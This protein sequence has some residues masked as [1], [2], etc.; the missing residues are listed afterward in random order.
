MT[1]TEKDYD[2]IIAPM[3]AVAGAPTHGPKLAKL[4]PPASSIIDWSIPCPSIFLTRE[5]ARKQSCKRPLAPATMRRIAAGLVK[6]VLTAAKPFIVRIGQT[7]WGDAGKVSD[8][9]QP[10][11]TV[12]SKAEHCVV[13]PTLV[14][15][16]SGHGPAS[17]RDPLATL[18]TG[19]HQGLVAAHLTKF[20]Q[21]SV[22]SSLDEPMHTITSGAGAAR[23]AGAAHAMGLV[24]A[25]LAKHY[26][27]RHPNE[28]IAGA[29]LSAPLPTLTGKCIQINAVAAHLSVFK[30]HNTGND[31]D[32]PTPTMT[33][34]SGGGSMALVAAFL[35]QYYG[36]G[37][38][39]QSLTEP[40]ATIVSRAR[41]GLVT[42]TIE[43][44]EYAVVD[45]G[46]RML[47][48]RELAAAQGF[49]ADY[50]LTG[51]KAEQ[52]ARIGNSVCPPVA[53]AVV[54]QQFAEEIAARKRAASA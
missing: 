42:V 2:E 51:T 9:E 36:S 22:G 19:N 40:L 50:I 25:F 45:I 29:P 48:P 31:L 8:L 34:A 38:Q 39:D 5:E 17:V 7:G 15:N 16:T 27:Q 11:T 43:G 10:L 18:T 4:H 13:A 47:S 53:E 26:S 41:M 49:P 46:M 24:S 33:A 30:A 32:E 35:I 23:P 28:D 37:G 20:R 1:G 14:V 3:L 12:T 21:N 6:Y 52:I 54:R 44:Q